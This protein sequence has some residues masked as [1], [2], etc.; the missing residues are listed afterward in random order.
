MFRSLSRTTT[1]AAVVLVLAVAFV[2]AAQA[3]PLGLSGLSPDNH[4]GWFDAAL[5]WLAGLLLGEASS[6]DQTRPAFEAA[7][8]LDLS[9][10]GNTV[11]SG[12]CIDP[13]GRPRPCF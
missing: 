1:A 10:G 9:A 5:T 2:P 4:S 6:P 3:S 12:A 7:T 11:H 8:S 13:A